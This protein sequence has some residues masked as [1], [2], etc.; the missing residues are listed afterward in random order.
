MSRHLR[1]QASEARIAVEAQTQNEHLVHRVRQQ[2]DDLLHL[3]RVYDP[4][5]MRMRFASF[6]SKLIVSKIP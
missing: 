2:H 4:R 3:L 1:P 6:S 5:A